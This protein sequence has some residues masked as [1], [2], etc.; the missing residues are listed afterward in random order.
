L[1]DIKFIGGYKTR[2]DVIEVAGVFNRAC[3]EHNGE[4]DIHAY[5]LSVVREGFC[6][7]ERID[8]V[9]PYL[10][11]VFLFLASFIALRYKRRS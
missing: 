7:K 3:K 1:G 2:G 4:L 5:R 8:R 10:A 11:V 6:E 9:R